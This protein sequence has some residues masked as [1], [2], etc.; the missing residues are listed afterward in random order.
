[1][2]RLFYPYL[3]ATTLPYGFLERQNDASRIAVK[4]AWKSDTKNQQKS[5]YQLMR[6]DDTPT[7]KSE[8]W[9]NRMDKNRVYQ[10]AC[11]IKL[12]KFPRSLEFFIVR[13][14]DTK[15]L[16]E[17]A[18]LTLRAGS[19]R[20]DE[21]GTVHGVAQV[22][23]HQL[24][25]PDVYDYDIALLKVKPPFRFSPNIRSIKLPPRKYSAA[26]GTKARVSGWGHSQVVRASAAV[27]AQNK[28]L[29]NWN[30]RKQEGNL[31]RRTNVTILSRGLC[32][33]IY[34]E[35]TARM[36]C[37]GRYPKGGRDACQGDSGGPLVSRRVLIGVVSWGIGCG[38]GRFPGVYTRVSVLR[39][40]IANTTGLC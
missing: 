27:M 38:L 28:L 12:N 10:R 13:E 33:E 29:T 6:G 25:D 17:S 21:G 15:V 22:I 20:H 7:E 36:L 11:M 14:L 1:M 5:S 3:T 39:D 40:W 23:P 2:S 35:L 4:G 31:L 30:I 18:D 8:D 34:P 37:A 16:L 24:Y 32:H 19:N 9:T 26:T